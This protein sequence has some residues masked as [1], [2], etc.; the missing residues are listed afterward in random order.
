MPLNKKIIESL[1]LTEVD[2]SLFKKPV[3]DTGANQPHAVAFAK[4]S[5]HQIDTLFLPDDNGYKYCL[6]CVDVY[7]GLTDAQP[8]M[9]VGNI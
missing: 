3:R 1:G 5:V 8:R 9:M 6:V 4:D 2:R 7:S